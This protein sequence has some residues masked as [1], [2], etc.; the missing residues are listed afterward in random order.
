MTDICADG[1]LAFI[2]LQM[3]LGVVGTQCRVVGRSSWP[4]LQ[5]HTPVKTP[6]CAILP[7]NARQCRLAEFRHR[8]LKVSCLGKW[9]LRTRCLKSLPPLGPCCLSSPSLSIKLFP[10]QSRALHYT[11]LLHQRKASPKNL[12]YLGLFLKYVCFHCFTISEIFFEHGFCARQ[13]F[14]IAANNIVPTGMERTS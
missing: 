1:T 8:V 3:P 7:R 12:Q 5:W 13:C 14:G 6:F 4:A 10:P 9:P 11:S 2:A